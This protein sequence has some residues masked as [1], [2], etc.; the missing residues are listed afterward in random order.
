MPPSL[1]EAD[2]AREKARLALARSHN[3]LSEEEYGA[4]LSLLLARLDL[5]GHAAA[6]PAAPAPAAAAAK[7]PLKS[8]L[9]A[10]APAAAAP[11]EEEKAAAAEEAREAHDPQTALIKACFSGNAAMVS[12][13]LSEGG[14]DVNAANE[15]GAS[16]LMYTCLGKGASAEAIGLRL[17]DLGAHV[18]HRDKQGN[19]ALTLACAHRMPVLAQMLVSRRAEL[20]FR[21][22][23]GLSPLDIAMQQGLDV[24]AHDIRSAGGLEGSVL[25]A[26]Y[27]VLT[28]EESRAAAEQEEA[29]RERARR[30][31]D[32]ASALRLGT[33]LVRACKARDRAE[34]LRLLAAGASTECVVDD[35]GIR[36]GQ[37][38][39]YISLFY[40]SY[41]EAVAK[42]LVNSG[43]DVN[44][45]WG[46]GTVLQL[47]A[48]SASPA[49]VKLMLDRGARVNDENENLEKTALDHALEQSRPDVAAVLRAHGGKTRR[50]LRDEASEPPG[51]SPPPRRSPAPHGTVLQYT[52]AEYGAEV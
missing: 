40:Q 15:F 32:A 3:L 16:A 13:L 6:A 27:G 43:A 8:A 24:V 52:L 4:Q 44:F 38:P 31:A 18:S 21:G 47:A 19:S 51:L 17:I 39:L 37:S 26:K 2:F 45:K 23:G 30:D 1:S 28:L 42:A 50:E 34:A 35:E 7:P 10:A 36:R 33:Q 14:V 12:K 48:I 25:K 5:G 29:A 9:K 22:P 46:F 49:L 20:N 11:D 41:D